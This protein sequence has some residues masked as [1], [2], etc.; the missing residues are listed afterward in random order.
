MPLLVQKLA[1]AMYKNGINI[2]IEEGDLSTCGGGER[3]FAW[4]DLHYSTDPKIPSTVD[5]PTVL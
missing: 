1:M 2:D 4:L 5:D 3:W